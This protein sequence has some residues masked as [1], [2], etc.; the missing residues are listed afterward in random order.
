M[1]VL[2]ITSQGFVVLREQGEACLLALPRSKSPVV[3]FLTSKKFRYNVHGF[4]NEFSVEMLVIWF[5]P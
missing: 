3:F 4:C 5:G 1:S 2:C